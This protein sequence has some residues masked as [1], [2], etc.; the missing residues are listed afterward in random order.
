MIEKVKNTDGT[1]L[2]IGESGAGKELVAR[3]IHYGSKRATRSFI[4]INCGA[5]PDDLAHKLI[6]YIDGGNKYETYV[7]CTT[8]K[9]LSI[10]IKEVYKS[11]KFVNQPSFANS[12]GQYLYDS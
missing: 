2:I 1:V 10:F 9:M 12:Q 3:A 5:L 11:E 6:S 4:A 7:M 8:T